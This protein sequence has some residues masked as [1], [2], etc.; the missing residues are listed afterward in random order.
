MCLGTTYV[1]VVSVCS[2]CMFNDFGTVMFACALLG[3]VVGWFKSYY[4][5]GCSCRLLVY[6]CINGLLGL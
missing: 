5:V 1:T 6:V 2:G 3:F 4:W